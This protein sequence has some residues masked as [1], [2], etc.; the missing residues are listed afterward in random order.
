MASAWRIFNMTTFALQ[1]CR[2]ES[3]NR[4]ESINCSVS[5]GRLLWQ[6]LQLEF[7]H[8]MKNKVFCLLRRCLLFFVMYFRLVHS[9]VRLI[10]YE[11]RRLLLYALQFCIFLD[12]L[13][14]DSRKLHVWRYFS[15]YYRLRKS[16]LFQPTASWHQLVLLF[17]LIILA[18]KAQVESLALPHGNIWF[19]QQFAH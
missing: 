7:K 3:I 5:H 2:A 1:H 6:F 19:V 4:L 13:Q 11:A 18:S 16:Q 9:I 17:F 10:L 12:Y 14:A 15:E 8:C